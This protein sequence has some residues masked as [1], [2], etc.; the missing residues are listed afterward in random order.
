MKKLSRHFGVRGDEDDVSNL[1]DHDSTD[2][3]G[4]SDVYSDPDDLNLHPDVNNSFYKCKRN[5][6]LTRARQTPPCSTY[7]KVLSYCRGEPVRNRDTNKTNE[8]EK[9]TD[10]P[11]NYIY[12]ENPENDINTEAPENDTNTNNPEKDDRNDKEDHR[13]VNDVQD[14]MTGN[15]NYN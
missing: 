12:T 10:N 2:V 9:N 3:K 4:N 6:Y 7:H 5:R 11:E 14:L 15:E 1:D 13:L 8:K